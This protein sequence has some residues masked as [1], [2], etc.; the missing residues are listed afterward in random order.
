MAIRIPADKATAHMDFAGY[1]ADTRRLN[2]ADHKERCWLIAE[3][4]LT[5]G[6][7]SRRAALRFAAEQTLHDVRWM[8]GRWPVIRRL[9]DERVECPVFPF[10]RLIRAVESGYG[11][12]IDRAL[13]ELVTVR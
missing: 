5:F 3:R 10:A 8:R 7:L 12:M 11:P 2:A 1:A 4:G 13:D 6:A 9:V